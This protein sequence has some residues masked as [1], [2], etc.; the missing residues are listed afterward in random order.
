MEYRLWSMSISGEQTP[1]AFSTGNIF[2]LIGAH[3]SLVPG[4]CSGVLLLRANRVD[5]FLSPYAP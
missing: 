2:G 5:S 3:M 1:K 4:S